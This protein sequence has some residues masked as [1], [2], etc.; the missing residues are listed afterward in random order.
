M[1]RHTTDK[2]RKEVLERTEERGTAQ[3]YAS[4]VEDLAEEHIRK[5]QE[6]GQDAP[7]ESAGKVPSEGGAK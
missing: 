7:G 2:E 3:P 5:K 4:E 6:S 1:V